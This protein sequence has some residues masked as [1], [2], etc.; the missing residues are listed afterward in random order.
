MHHKA[1]DYGAFTLDEELRLVP[2]EQLSGGSEAQRA[3]TGR[4]GHP[5]CLPREAPLPAEPYLR[6]YREQVFWRRPSP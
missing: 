3:L 2:S 4:A 5:I 6:W 1:F